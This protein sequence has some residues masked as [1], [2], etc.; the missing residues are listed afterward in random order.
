VSSYL[1]FRPRRFVTCIVLVIM[2]VFNLVSVAGMIA[3][4]EESTA[5]NYENLTVCAAYG[6]ITSNSFPDLIILDVRN[7]SEYVMG[8]LSGVTLIPCNVLETRIGELEEHRNHEIVVYC[9]SGL[10]SQ[11]AC[12]ILVE[13]SF[14][15][16]YNMLGGIIAWIE[17]D[18]PIWTTSHHIT[19]DTA[20]DEIF[21]QIKPLLLFFQSYCT[22]CAENQTS[23]NGNEPVNVSLS[24]LEQGENFTVILVTYEINGTVFEFTITRALLWSYE[25]LAEDFNRTARLISTQV[26]VE[27][28]ST[29]SFSLDYHVQ[30]IEYNFSL[31][32]SLS[33]LNSETYNSS[34]TTVC[35]ATADKPEVA[36]FELVRFNSSVTLSRQFSILGKVS[37][38]L[39]KGYEK[40]ENATLAQLADAYY[41]MEEENKHLSKIVERQLTQYKN[42]VLTGTGVITD[43]LGGCDLRP[44]LNGGGG[45]GG[46]SEPTCT[47]EWWSYYW[48][49]CLG[50][51][52]PW[53]MA[54]CAWACVVGSILCGPAYPA[55]L[56]ECLAISCGVS[57]IV[58]AVVCAIYAMLACDCV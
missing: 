34:F 26:D 1:A 38:E 35:C 27:N 37:K 28:A 2:M 55:C 16:V 56:G 5:H 32:T 17:A 33:P 23:T 50:Q 30:H 12:E 46:G 49:S 47:L 15:K 3:Q 52:V 20:D 31:H 13:N 25:E 14:T 54:L 58:D 10:R 24:V 48:I 18:Y 40:G 19:V 42:V 57:L 21:L 43:P 7:Q 11:T 9:R 8:H 29:L 6:M 51:Q 53:D 22:S 4:A 45:G 41:A 44:C 36:S 39:G